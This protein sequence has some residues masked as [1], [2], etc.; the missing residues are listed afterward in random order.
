MMVIILLQNKNQV[1]HAIDTKKKMTVPIISCVFISVFTQD[2]TP[3]GM[4]VECELT[5]SG[6]PLPKVVGWCSR[7]ALHQRTQRKASKKPPAAI[8]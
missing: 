7:S 5:V 3:E 1:I 2:C 6:A 8:P 4:Q